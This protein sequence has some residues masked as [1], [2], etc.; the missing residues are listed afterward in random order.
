MVKTKTN[1]KLYFD[2]AFYQAIMLMNY[3][4][5]LFRS[6]EDISRPLSTFLFIALIIAADVIGIKL[7]SSRKEYALKCFLITIFPFGVYTLFTY[8][9]LL[10]TYII[11]SGIVVGLTTAIFAIVLYK[12]RLHN[13][14]NKCQYIMGMLSRCLFY[15]YFAIVICMTIIL[16]FMLIN[17]IAGNNLISTKVDSYE[18]VGSHYSIDDHM[19][20]ILLLQ[21]SK[22]KKLDTTEKLK[23]LNTVAN[24]EASNMG[25]SHIINLGT[26]KLDKQI[27]GQYSNEK[28]TVY[29]DID[30]LENDD[31]NDVLNSVCHEVR[32]CY[33]HLIVEEYE[34]AAPESKNLMLY[35]DAIIYKQEFEHYGDLTKDI[36][37][38]YTLNCEVD[39]RNCAE[40]AVIVYNKLIS[41]YNVSSENS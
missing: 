18:T 40:N 38:Y 23:V 39:A 15:M 34:S 16:V 12:I 2:L 21:E 22:W 20:E 26:S 41:A 4:T 11:C 36:M 29:I 3:L 1:F 13:R 10:E 37:R 30:H 6:I 17:R 14:C 5:L 7:L 32:H 35:K 33:Q 19:D 9:K 28:Y 31:V 24:I 27:L 25:I 8:R